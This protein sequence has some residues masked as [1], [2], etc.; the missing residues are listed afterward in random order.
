MGLTER[1]IRRYARHILLPE[2]GGKGQ[3]RLLAASVRIVGEVALAN[4]ANA[5]LQ[6]AGVGTAVEPGALLRLEV[7]RAELPNAYVHV[8]ARGAGW[9]I[10]VGGEA[11]EDPGSRGPTETLLLAASLAAFEALRSLLN[12]GR[13][14]RS[15]D[16][17]GQDPLLGSAAP[18]APR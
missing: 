5:Y 12:L 11:S 16:V 15:W 3:E 6:A 17:D 18:Q 14:D 8:V 2:V 7:H 13:P 1:Q 4:L 9:R 10:V